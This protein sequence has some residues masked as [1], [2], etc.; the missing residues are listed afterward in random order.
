[1]RNY[2]ACSGHA[3]LNI[4][5]PKGGDGLKENSS[6]WAL[7]L[8]CN[9]SIVASERDSPFF[10]PYLN[11]V[12]SHQQS[13]TLAIDLAGYLLLSCGL[14]LQV[15]SFDCQVHNLQVNLLQAGEFAGKTEIHEAIPASIVTMHLRKRKYL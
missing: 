15:D 3:L 8:E 10:I 5:S 1:M 13:Y 7:N 6:L 2:I 9:F 11:S 12:K 4:Q 14:F